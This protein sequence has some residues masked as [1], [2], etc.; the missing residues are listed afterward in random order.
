MESE[1]IKK[2][3]LRKKAEEI[4]Q[5]QFNP[6][7]D[8]PKDDDYIHELLVHQ[9]ELELQYHELKEAQIQLEDSRNKYFDLYNF[10][11]VGYFTLDKKGIIL[12]VNLAGA[13]LLGVERLNLVKRAFIQFIKPDYRNK[14]HLHTMKVLETETKETVDLKL[15][16]DNDYFY[17]HLETINVQDE[18]GNFK[19]FRITITDINE[20]KNTQNSLKKNEDYREIFFNNHTPMIL[21][22]PVNLN[23]I[24]AN[25]AAINFY[26]YKLE[27][28]VKMKVADLNISDADLVMAEM[29]KAVSEEKNHFKFKHRLSNGKIRN[30]DVHSGLIKQKDENVLYS[31]IY[32]ITAQEKAISDQEKLKIR[33]K[34]LITKLEISNKELEQFAYVSSHDLREPLRMIT[35]FLQLLQKNYSDDLDKDANDY[36]NYAVDGA[37]RM[38]LVI[39]DLLEYSR[40]GNEERE[41][42]HLKS[43]NIL[44]K[45]LINLKPVIESTNAIVTHDPLPLIYANDQMMIQLFQNLIGNAIKYHGKETPEIHISSDK[46]NDEYIFSVKDNGIGMDQKHLER[47]FTMFQRLHTHEEYEGTG[48][49]LAISEKIVLQHSGKIWAESKLGKGTTFYFTIPII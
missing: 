5:N 1:K 33:L 14:F 2:D 19:E 25:T 6:L 24:N 20:L 13:T 17:A 37:K 46:V 31:I 16:N 43:E 45:V 30:V 29:Q 34:K 9:I 44:E 22:D 3:N 38:D 4:L 35:S 8:A 32:D 10:A 12:E 28:L 39:K 49:G 41:F 27:E 48:I 47:I 42:K 11:P 40:I 26:G 21:I 23:I 18:N 7:K 15:K 36:I